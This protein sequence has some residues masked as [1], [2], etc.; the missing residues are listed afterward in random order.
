MALGVV[1]F[2]V[3]SIFSVEVSESARR[4]GYMVVA[5][6][7]TG[8]AEWDLRGMEHLI[9]ET[10]IHDEL[11]SLPV[12]IPWVTPS[13]RRDRWQRAKGVGFTQF[14][15]IV[16]PTSV[17]AA[18]GPWTH[19]AVA[20]NGA[21]FHVA[22]LGQGPMVLMLHGFPMF[23]W[24]WRTH[25]LSIAE[26]G[27]RAVAMDLRGYGGSDRPPRGYDPYTLSAD[28]AG[29]I[30]SLGAEDATIVGHGWGGF[31]AWTTAALHPDSVRAI[32]PVAMAHPCRLRDSLRHD[33]DQRRASRY[34][35]GF[36]LQDHDTQGPR[37]RTASFRCL[38]WTAGNGR[39]L[40][41]DPAPARHS[42]ARQTFP[43]SDHQARKGVFGTGQGSYGWPVSLDLCRSGQVAFRV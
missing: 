12:V 31:L 11:L 32:A 28:V 3:D 6:I 15:T 8:D 35:F 13:L 14:Q 17:I 24:T 9:K 18:E 39:G 41:W 29:V 22:E 40:W 30:G 10:E 5:G 4:L 7:M 2:G 21:R 34:A 26:A 1:L 33:A 23:W 42:N 27:Y 20:A 19:R 43:D 36:R 16:D 38:P 25:L 37:P